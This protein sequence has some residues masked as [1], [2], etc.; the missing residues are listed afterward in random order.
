MLGAFAWPSLRCTIGLTERGRAAAIVLAAAGVTVDKDLMSRVGV[1][2][3]E[4]A[5]CVLFVLV[6]IGRKTMRQAAK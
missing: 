4:R 3:I 2:D 6:D 1:K 5:H